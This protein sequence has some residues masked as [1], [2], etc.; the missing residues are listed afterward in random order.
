MR[1]DDGDG[2]DQLI[3]RLRAKA[4]QQR[5][6]IQQLQKIIGRKSTQSQP[7]TRDNS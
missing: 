6:E 5:T 3:R 2:L 1:I 4:A 7:I